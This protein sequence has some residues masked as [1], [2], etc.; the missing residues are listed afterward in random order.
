MVNELEVYE[1]ADKS[2]IVT[3][4]DA[5]GV[6]I[7][8][9]GYSF[10]FC[11]KEDINDSDDNAIIKKVITSHEDPTHG[12]TRI[13]INSD[14][15]IGKSGVYVYDLQWTDSSNNRYPVIEKTKF[16]IKQCVGDSFTS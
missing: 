15:T 8:I 14:D 2:W 10:L 1:N 12:I 4:T 6:A 16:E 9:T 13:T 5:E 11:V 3:I 7:N